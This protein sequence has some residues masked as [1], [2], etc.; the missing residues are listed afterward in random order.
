MQ[1]EWV[2]VVS[3]DDLF[4][5]FKKCLFHSTDTNEQQGVE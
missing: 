4:C 5:F 1:I 3:N 2:I